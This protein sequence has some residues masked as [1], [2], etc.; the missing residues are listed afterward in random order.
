M[1]IDT[2]QS[3]SFNQNY[4]L[5]NVNQPSQQ[6]RDNFAIIK[7]HFGEYKMRL[8]IDF[9]SVLGSPETFNIF[10]MFIMI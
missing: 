10:N 7:K 6:F 8:Y 4:P 1:S 5:P 9:H 2:G 3:L